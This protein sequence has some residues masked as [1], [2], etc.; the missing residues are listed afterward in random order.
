MEPKGD[1]VMT[2]LRVVLTG[3]YAGAWIATFAVRWTGLDFVFLVASLA[4]A[5][6]S[7]A[8]LWGAL[9]AYKREND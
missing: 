7:L 4:I 1:E 6:P 8:V 5:S 9:D 3:L 2:A